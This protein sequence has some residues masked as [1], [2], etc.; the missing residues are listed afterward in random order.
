MAVR[1]YVL[2]AEDFSAVMRPTVDRGGFIDG[3]SDP[4][5]ASSG[6]HIRT[7]NDDR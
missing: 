2:P 4:G 1:S 6:S 7:C 5:V 3:L